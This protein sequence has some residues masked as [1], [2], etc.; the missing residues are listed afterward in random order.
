MQ[1]R[2]RRSA[3]LWVLVL[4]AVLVMAGCGG[5]DAA[6]Q[7]GGS[8]D[9]EPRNPPRA[10][11]PHEAGSGGAVVSSAA[12][13]GPLVKVNGTIYILSREAP[14][15]EGELGEPVGRVERTLNMEA[16]P[17]AGDSNFLAKGTTIYSIEGR[18]IEEAVAAE[19]EGRLLVLK[20][21]LGPGEIGFME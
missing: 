2:N 11:E 10:G 14:L 4:A 17:E 19:Y 7:A 3:L 20:P 21:D 1:V 5:Q 16:T 13:V 12:W 8:Q 6:G 18:S 9:V 15:S